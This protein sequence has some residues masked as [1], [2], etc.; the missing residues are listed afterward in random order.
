[1]LRKEVRP[2]SLPLYYL[3]YY[4]GTYDE[5]GHQFVTQRNTLVL[6][7]LNSSVIIICVEAETLCVAHIEGKA[8]VMMGI[9]WERSAG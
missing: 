9:R 5:L 8:G 2:M 7:F 1:M 4:F 3:L 6:P